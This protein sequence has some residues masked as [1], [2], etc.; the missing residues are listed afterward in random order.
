ML[1][2]RNSN[3]AK[4]ARGI[5]EEPPAPTSAVQEQDEEEV[6]PFATQQIHPLG[7]QPLGNA[8]LGPQGSECSEGVRDHRQRRREGLGVLA[9]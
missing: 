8:L 5:V 2:R 1:Q 7:V 6:A 3:R 4:R 9:A